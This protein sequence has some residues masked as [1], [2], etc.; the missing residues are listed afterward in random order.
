MLGLVVFPI[1]FF[2]AGFLF[3]VV[4]PYYTPIEFVGFNMVASI[5]ALVIANGVTLF[6]TISFFIQMVLLH[7]G[8]YFTFAFV[9][10]ATQNIY[11]WMKEKFPMLGGITCSLTMLALVSVMMTVCFSIQ[12]LL[13][14]IY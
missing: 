14:L 8:I 5:I 2:I 12:Y 1:L 9:G 10:L 11:R 3:K 13:T 6:I 4:R 7:V